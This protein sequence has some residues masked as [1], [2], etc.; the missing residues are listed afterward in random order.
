MA[1]RQYDKKTKRK[2]TKG[3]NDETAN[4]QDEKRKNDTTKKQNQ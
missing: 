4:Q 3:R 1:K 2:M